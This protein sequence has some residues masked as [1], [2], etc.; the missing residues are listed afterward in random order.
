MYV[1]NHFYHIYNRG[2]DGRN[3]FNEERDYLRFIHCLYEFND[4]N[5]ALPYGWLLKKQEAF[6]KKNP[7]QLIVNIL[8]FCFMPNHFHLILQQIV[9]GGITKFMRKLGT[10][11]TMFFNEKYA[12][13]GVL[14]QGKFKSILVETDEYLLHL[15][16]Y[17]HLNPVELIEPDWKEKGLGN[18]N[19]T[20][21]FL[22]K[23]RWSS[24][25]D[26]LGIKNSPSVTRRD[27][28]LDYFKEPRGYEGFVFDF[29]KEDIA[30]IKEVLLDDV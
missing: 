10:G 14:F 4:Q 13:S 28:L 8:C 2:T 1:T 6:N 15:S 25:I 19:K 23:Y 7:R 9:D 24:F 11:Y 16:R 22:K 30:K 17:I 27:F 5:P 26:Y 18:L 20:K 12:R 3:I 21:S 29:L